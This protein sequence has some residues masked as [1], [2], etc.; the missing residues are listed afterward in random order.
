M[1]HAVR[2]AQAALDVV[3]KSKPSPA[4]RMDILVR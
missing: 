3:G 4:D 1:D 2:A